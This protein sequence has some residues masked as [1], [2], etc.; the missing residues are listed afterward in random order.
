MATLVDEDDGLASE[1]GCDVR[2]A[3]DVD[4][5]VAGRLE[6]RDPATCARTP[7]KSKDMPVIADKHSITVCN[8]T[9]QL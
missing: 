9:L 1:L 3:D 5:T 2:E 7:Q 4:V 6:T 8:I